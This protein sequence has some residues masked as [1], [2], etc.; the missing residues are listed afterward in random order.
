MGFEHEEPH[1]KEYVFN[2]WVTRC[3]CF[4]RG[5]YFI[6]ILFLLYFILTMKVQACRCALP[7][8]EG[9]CFAFDT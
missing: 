9:K 1:S 7:S 4:G 3:P 2:M 6:Y 8:L 5:Q